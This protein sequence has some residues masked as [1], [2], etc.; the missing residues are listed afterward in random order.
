[1]KKNEKKLFEQIVKDYD[2]DS[3][4]L[5]PKN[6]QRNE[7]NKLVREKRITNGNLDV[8]KEF[9]VSTFTNAK[10]NGVEKF[11]AKA[12]KIG[13]VLSIDTV[14]L[15]GFKAGQ[16][17]KIVGIKD[18]ETLILDTIS[19]DKNG[20]DRSRKNIEFNI[21]NNI[22][23]VSIFNHDTINPMKIG[24]NEKI[25]FTKKIMDSTNKKVALTQNGSMGTVK[26]IDGDYLIVELDNKKTIK[27][28]AKENNYFDYAYAITD[29]KSQGMSI[30]KVQVLGDSMMANLNAFYVQITRAKQELKFYTKNLEEFIERAKNQQYK[31]STLDYTMKADF[32][33]LEKKEYKNW[34]T[35]LLEN[36]KEDRKNIKFNLKKGLE[37]GKSNTTTIESNEHK[38]RQLG[39][40]K[41]TNAKL[42]DRARERINQLIS[43]TSLVIRRFGEWRESISTNVKRNWLEYRK[44]PNLAGKSKIESLQKINQFNKDLEKK[45]KLFEAL[46]IELQDKRDIL[47]IYRDVFKKDKLTQNQI[48]KK[49]ID[50]IDVLNKE[51]EK[52]VKIEEKPVEKEIEKIKD[53][54]SEKSQKEKIEKHKNKIKENIEITNEKEEIESKKSSKKYRK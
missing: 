48:I 33:A 24:I 32:R 17:F 9:E 47:E 44:Y 41:P 43:T 20:R 16:K 22:D 40:T 36:I 21:K 13:Q 39:K 54:K 2:E 52:T 30:K 49:I 18:D 34:K 29:Y 37:N 7:L 10:P 26:E 31:E 8:S 35:D 3:I 11:N 5:A 12:Y 14:K 46:Q 28:N 53:E 50:D 19:N 23:L 27:F 51:L 15:K 6:T 4:I 38:A 42:D 45:E 1:M 25:I